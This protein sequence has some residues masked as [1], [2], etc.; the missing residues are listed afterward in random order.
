MKQEVKPFLE[1]SY[2]GINVYRGSSQSSHLVPAVMELLRKSISLG[3]DLRFRG[4]DELRRAFEERRC[5]YAFDMNNQLVGFVYL[6]DIQSKQKFCIERRSLIID[7]SARGKRL[8]A[9]LIQGVFEIM[10]KDFPQ[11]RLLSITSNPLIVKSNKKNHFKE[12]RYQELKSSYGLDVVKECESHPNLSYAFKVN[13]F[14]A[15]ALDN[16]IITN[17]STKLRMR[18]F[19]REPEPSR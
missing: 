9:R 10:E 7:P 17:T 6:K 16:V 12:I 3:E 4:V 19:V 15:N 14:S 5:L 1:S 8:G 11:S 2:M 13:P 18:I